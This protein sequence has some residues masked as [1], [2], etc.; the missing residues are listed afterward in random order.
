MMN[1][2]NMMTPT[3]QHSDLTERII[4][5]AMRVHS[6][7]GPGFLESVY[8]KS[9]EIELKRRGLE[10]ACEH[11]ITVYYTGI[12]VGEFVSDMLVDDAV[13]VENKAVRALAPAHEVQL[14]NYL[15]ATHL[16]I[17][18]LLNFGAGK[19]EFKRKARLY[20]ES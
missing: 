12:P 11:R 9:L 4:G 8:Q 15:T 13:L 7:L 1:M 2:M 10:V 16:D 18:L 17:G 14:V 20:S 3:Y 19:L 5:A 6:A